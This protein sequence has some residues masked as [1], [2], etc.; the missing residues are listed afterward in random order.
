ML[1]MQESGLYL[2]K[3]QEK[4]SKNCVQSRVLLDVLSFP[5]RVGVGGGRWMGLMNEHYDVH[6][7]SRF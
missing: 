7:A 1:Q 5:W 3:N 4:M 6:Q 2:G